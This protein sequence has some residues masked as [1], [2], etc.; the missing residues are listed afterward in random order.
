MIS[1]HYVLRIKPVFAYGQGNETNPAIGDDEYFLIF[2]IVHKLALKF[3]AC[4][5]MSEETLNALYIKTVTSLPYF[6]R[7]AGRD[8]VFVFPSGRGA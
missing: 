4:S 2:N 8:H 7:S 1:P 3:N 6:R 5:Q